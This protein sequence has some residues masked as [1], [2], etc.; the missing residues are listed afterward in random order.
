M[1]VSFNYNNLLAHV[2][3][4][5]VTLQRIKA[6]TESVKE[7]KKQGSGTVLERRHEVS[8]LGHLGCS[9]EL[10]ILTSVLIVSHHKSSHCPVS[11]E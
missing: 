1:H 5:S 3:L 8:L 11:R 10:P 6:E 9:K 4:F 7:P 2:I